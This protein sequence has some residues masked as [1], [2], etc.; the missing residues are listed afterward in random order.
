M[1]SAFLEIRFNIVALKV[2]E[3]WSWLSRLRIPTRDR[4][5]E[6]QLLPLPR[7]QF[8]SNEFRSGSYA[9]FCSDLL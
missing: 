7:M 1:A 3:S 8:P 4:R 5:L 9:T 6:P 2:P